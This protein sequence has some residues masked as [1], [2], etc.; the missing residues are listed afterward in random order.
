MPAPIHQ[1]DF[2]PEDFI[3][4]AQMLENIVLHGIDPVV[5]ALRQCGEQMLE[6]EAFGA[7]QVSEENLIICGLI[8]GAAH[9]I[10]L[11][12]MGQE[13]AD[14]YEAASDLIAWLLER[15][16]IQT[17]GNNKAVPE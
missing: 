15:I 13:A 12:K 8:I 5:K 16:K 4:V 3:R 14:A 9:T 6:G 11:T 10:I 7:V 2:A 17:A 1:A